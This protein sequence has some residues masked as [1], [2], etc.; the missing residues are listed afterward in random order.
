MPL[1][2][3]DVAPD[4]TLMNEKKEPVKLSDLKGKKVVLLFYPMDFSPT[5]TT[6]H[7]TFGPAMGKIAA[8]ANTVIFGV[9]ADH[10]FSHEAYKKQ[11]NIP[12]SLLSDP[13]RT[14]LKA[15]D[16]FAGLEP[17]NCAK[18]GTVVIGADGKITHYEEVSMREPRTI[19][20]LAAAASK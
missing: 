12:Y 18:R 9:N 15:Y 8:D 2:P 20:A 16:M 7:C 6:E 14:M 4:F 11:F 3:G 10:P 19:E 5:C 1:K 17:Y 13:T